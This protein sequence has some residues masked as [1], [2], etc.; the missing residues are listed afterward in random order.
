MDTTNT[1]TLTALAFAVSLALASGQAAAQAAPGP[2]PGCVVA[3]QFGGTFTA[4]DGSG[5]EATVTDAGVAV[6]C[7]ASAAENGSAIGAN[8]RAERG[9][10]A[11]GSGA[12]AVGLGGSIAIGTGASATSDPENVGRAS[13]ALGAGANAANG[14]VAVGWG[15]EASAPDEVSFGRAFDRRRLTNVANGIA[16]SDAATVGQLS[17]FASALGGG[18]I[19]SSGV[20]SPP[21]YVFLS[22]S[23]FANV[24]D[25]LAD[26]DNRVTGLEAGGGGQ[27][28]PGPQ[29]PTGPT[30]PTGPAGE[31]GAADPLAVRYDDDARDTATLAGAEGTR[32]GNVSD[33]VAP[34]DAVTIRQMRQ[35]DAILS[36][37]IDTLGDRL[38]TAETRI[39]GL[40]RRI[41]KVGA[42][43]AATGLMA[44]AS[45]GNTDQW[46]VGAA[47]ANFDG[48]EAV[49]IGLTGG[50]RLKN[51]RPIGFVFGGS[52]AG[53]DA[54][55]G[56]G[57]SVGLGSR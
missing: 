38:T 56:L 28:I 52:T 19:F 35:A 1:N 16:A 7:S 26:L 50:W 34:T 55:V 54:A 48:E 44:A 9:A 10:V 2:A 23:T 15:S 32:I 3:T 18:S 4:G 21:S 6:G 25:A 27:P 17:P 36:T 42:L 57:F 14:G 45:G 49:A 24:G 13:V 39:A 41:A 12:A 53:G 11:L 47:V 40:D 22:G 33:G 29:G 37:R 8:T 46:R 51:G 5:G 30:G 20:F 43:G 31:P